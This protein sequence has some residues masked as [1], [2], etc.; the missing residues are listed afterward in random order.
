[1]EITIGIYALIYIF[2]FLVIPGFLARRFYYHGEFSKQININTN[3]VMNFIYSLF[4]GILLSLLFI[5]IFNCFSKQGINI[6]NILNDFDTNFVTSLGDEST[7]KTKSISL[8][9]KGKFDGL[10]ENIY[11]DYLPFLGG[12]YFF[13]AIIGFFLSKIV[14]LFSW[15]TRW[16]FLRFSNNW[17]YLFSGKILKFKKYI[18]SE[19]DHRLKVKYTYLDILVSEKGE[20]TTLYSGLFAD[21][22]L[23]PQ[24]TCKLEKIHLYKAIRYKKNDDGTTVSKNIPGNLFTIVGDR[25][26]NINC[27]YICFDEEESNNKKF[28]NQKNLL[29]PV[30]IAST[31]FFLTILISFTFSLNIFNSSWYNQE[32]LSKSFFYKVLIIFT[33]N[34]GIGLITPFEIFKKEKKVKFIGMKAYSLKIILIIISLCLIYISN[35]YF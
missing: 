24:D 30:Q 28:S 35:R 31:L 2:F 32:L 8:A 13:S 27:T 18:S 29:I 4:V 25:I 23:N 21:Y 10:S 16:K 9:K 7:D 5:S 33:L 1:M 26:L 11:S 15:D 20:E 22:D 14:L 12:I 34:F 3:S 19:I 6:D 17:H